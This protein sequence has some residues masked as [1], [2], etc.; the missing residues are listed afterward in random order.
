[1]KDVPR[2]ADLE[3]DE[4]PIEEL[5]ALVPDADPTFVAEVRERLNREC[6]ASNLMVAGWV[7]AGT[8]VLSLMIGVISLLRPVD[9]LQEDQGS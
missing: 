5:A 8:A 3:P 6:L 7:L 4:Q 2:P 1:M 9:H